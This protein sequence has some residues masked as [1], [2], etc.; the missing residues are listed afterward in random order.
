MYETAA[1]GKID[2]NDFINIALEVEHY[3]TPSQLLKTVNQIEHRLGRVRIEK[4]GARI[5]DIDIIFMEDTVV[6][7]DTLTI[8]H[9]LMHK[10]NFVLFPMVEIAPEFIH[11]VINESLTHILEDC[12]DTTVVE[13]IKLF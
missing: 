12:E 9:S 13:R 10:R 2:E 1:W 7:T 11:P 6:N 4:W 5:I 3:M 8:P